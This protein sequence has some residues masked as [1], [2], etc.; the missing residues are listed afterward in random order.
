MS[1]PEVASRFDEIYNSIYKTVLASITAKCGRVADIK[2]IAQE[3]Y[4]ELYRVLCKRGAN[5][6]ILP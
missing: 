6:E 4:L 2:D 3:T 5:F 1:N